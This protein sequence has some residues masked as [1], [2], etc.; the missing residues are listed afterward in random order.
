MACGS[1]ATYR[2]VQ[3]E[4][5]RSRR[6]SHLA[7]SFPSLQ[8]ATVSLN[9]F[10]RGW[11]QQQIAGVNASSQQRITKDTTLERPVATAPFAR[12]ATL[13]L[14][15]DVGADTSDCGVQLDS[16]FPALTSL[17]LVLGDQPVPVPIDLPANLRH[18]TVRASLS[19]CPLETTVR[20]NPEATS[21]RSIVAPSGR[22]AL[23][24]IPDAVAA[25][26]EMLSAGE[27]SFESGDLARFPNLRHLKSERSEKFGG[28]EGV[29]AE[30]R[31]LR[32]DTLSLVDV[33]ELAARC[34]RLES[35][36]NDLLPMDSPS[37]T[38]LLLKG[39]PSLRH[40]AGVFPGE[41]ADDD[42]ARVLHALPQWTIR[43]K[44][45]WDQRQGTVTRWVA[46]LP[47]YPSE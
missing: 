31:T 36:T 43:H 46:S 21:L 18:L 2:N 33:R 34:P 44:S 9:I 3:I 15:V 6:V 30:L 23:A 41:L 5:R 8:G 45:K 17:K 39:P 1:A 10:D 24:C 40:L 25:G 14:T 35:V 7:V 32:V 29:G 12:L 38:A 26:V 13:E 11:L 27:I 42:V 47:C 28:F 22:I 16:C 37:V 19:H 20:F 4:G